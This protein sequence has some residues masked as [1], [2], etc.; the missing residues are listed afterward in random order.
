MLVALTMKAKVQRGLCTADA[1]SLVS[2]WLLQCLV[3]GSHPADWKN[4]DAGS[5]KLKEDPK[6]RAEYRSWVENMLSGEIKQVPRH[7]MCAAQET[8]Q[9]TASTANNFNS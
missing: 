1:I 6:A 8:S 7:S 3:F 4:I 2:D 5:K 9:I